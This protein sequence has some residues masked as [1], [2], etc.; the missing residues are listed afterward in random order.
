[1]SAPF[2]LQEDGRLSA[3]DQRRFDAEVA[4]MVEEARR[5]GVLRFGK[6]RGDVFVLRCGKPVGAGPCL[7]RRGHEGAHAPTWEGGAP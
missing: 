2:A 4:T 5:T 1:M 3:A 7:R 6:G